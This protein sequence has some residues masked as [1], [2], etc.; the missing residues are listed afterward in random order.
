MSSP[1]SSKKPGSPIKKQASPISSPIPKSLADLPND[2]LGKI[3]SKLPTVEDKKNFVITSK[4]MHSA[5]FMTPSS[6]HIKASLK[7]NVLPK[8]VSLSNYLQAMTINYKPTREH[9][10]FK[11]YFMKLELSLNRYFDV[12]FLTR[13]SAKSNFEGPAIIVLQRYFTSKYQLFPS[14]RDKRFSVLDLLAHEELLT[15][16][17]K[18]FEAQLRLSSGK[19]DSD[20]NYIYFDIPG[21]RAFETYHNRNKPFKI[22]Y[23]DYDYISFLPSN[24]PEKEKEQIIKELFDHFNDFIRAIYGCF[25]PSYGGTRHRPTRHRPNPKR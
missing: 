17:S 23:R 24:I 7:E 13:N 10:L 25:Y 22:N 15:E 8:F 14:T 11:G 21:R 12:S 3:H 4:S 20:I 2:V 16:L 5:P 18:P 1:S 9:E 19:G 6:A